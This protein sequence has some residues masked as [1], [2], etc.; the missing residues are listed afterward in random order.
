MENFNQDALAQKLRT[1]WM[2]R[3]AHFFESVD[4]TQVVARKLIAENCPDGTLVVARAQS[5]GF[6]RRDR[7][8][9]SARG[10]LWA[11]LVLPAAFPRQG[12]GAFSLVC[13]LAIAQAIEELVA[14]RCHLKWPN[15]VWCKDKKVCGILSEME[16]K[17]LILG[18][19]VNVENE[20]PPELQNQAAN[21]AQL[22]SKKIDRLLLCAQILNKLEIYFQL[23]KEQSFAPFYEPYIERCL[24]KGEAV[25]LQEGSQIWSGTLTEINLQGQLVLKDKF[26]EQKKFSAGEVS[27]RLNPN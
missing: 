4:S 13:A 16:E 7:I 10:G 8:W 11:S 23:F 25:F 14:I 2:G 12:Y 3:A 26:G 17:F 18:F 27:L 24:W 22:S 19:G 1:R 15:D 5:A 21:L 20:L 6:G 9:D